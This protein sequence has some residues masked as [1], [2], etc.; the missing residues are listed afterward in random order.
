MAWIS[1]TVGWE[2]ARF[3]PA[4]RAKAGAGTSGPL[5]TWGFAMKHADF[6]FF[7]KF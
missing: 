6:T 1:S 4:L 7:H 2:N 5:K 3:S